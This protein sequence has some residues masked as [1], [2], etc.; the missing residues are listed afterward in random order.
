[1]AERSGVTGDVWYASP[2]RFISSPLQKQPADPAL[3]NKPREEIQ[4]SGKLSVRKK[5]EGGIKE[6]A[7]I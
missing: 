6:E 5:G 3:C 1:M 4:N 7:K 2:Q